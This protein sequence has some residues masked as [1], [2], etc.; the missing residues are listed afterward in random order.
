MKINRRPKFVACAHSFGE[1]ATNRPFLEIFHTMTCNP[2]SVQGSLR[3]CSRIL[4]SAATLNEVQ[5]EPCCGS[6][7]AAQIPRGEP[8]R[9]R[10]TK[11]AS[12][13]S[14]FDDHQIKTRARA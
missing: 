10:P 3:A 12:A 11:R 14:E 2:F 1:P 13:T 4:G 6:G 9:P 5:F 8:A 7:T